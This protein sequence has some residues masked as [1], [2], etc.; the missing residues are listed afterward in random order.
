[1]HSDLQMELGSCQDL[2]THHMRAFLIERYGGL[3][4]T[5]ELLA[6][7]IRIAC[8]AHSSIPIVYDIIITI[9]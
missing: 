3:W 1:M 2:F 6:K 8:V 5:L 4:A 9:E 7:Q